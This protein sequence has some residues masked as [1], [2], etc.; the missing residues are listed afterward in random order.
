MRACYIYKHCFASRSGG[1][2]AV[3]VIFWI[4]L[5]IGPSRNFN[6][7]YFMN[8][9]FLLPCTCR[10]TSKTIA[11]ASSARLYESVRALWTQSSSLRNA[12]SY[13]YT[14][15][16]ARL[17]QKRVSSFHTPI[18]NV[19]R[20]AS[21][22]AAAQTPY[23]DS[24][25]PFSESTS[26]L[27]KHERHQRHLPDSLEALDKTH[28]GNLKSE[29]LLGS[30]HA[31]DDSH[32]ILADDAKQRRSQRTW[33]GNAALSF[34]DIKGLDDGVAGAHSTFGYRDLIMR[35]TTLDAKGNWQAKNTPITKSML[36]TQHA[37]QVG[38]YFPAYPGCLTADWVLM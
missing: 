2:C 3:Q 1:K 24:N 28:R 18:R 21:S 11:P 36:C 27:H 9:L 7:A 12:S 10:A 5:S 6:T 4:I 25:H 19:K 20:N 17:N 23:F 31:Q 13:T 32:D 35:C 14:K 22:N 16:P 34:D 15:A 8:C 29:P 26:S 33:A 38:F 37:L 30:S